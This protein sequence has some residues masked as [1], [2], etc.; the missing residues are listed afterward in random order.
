MPASPSDPTWQTHA[1]KHGR[2][3]LSRTVR[4]VAV[5]TAMAVLVGLLGYLV[6]PP[7]FAART[8]LF[9]IASSDAKRS[10]V[11]S[12]AY[13]QEDARSLESI[14]STRPEDLSV[15]LRSASAISRLG[16]EV[17]ANSLRPCDTLIV[18]LAAHG[19]ADETGA[20]LLA[21]DFDL[22]KPQQGRVEIKQLL[23]EI[24]RSH[25]GTKLVIV[26]AGSIDHDPRLGLHANDF[27]RQLADAVKETGDPTLWVL[28][29]HGERQQ[30]HRV[31]LVRRTVFGSFVS[32]GLKGAADVNRDGSVTLDEL[33]GFTSSNVSKWVSA[34]TN[35][36][37]RQTPRLTWGGVSAEQPNPLLLKLDRRQQEEH[38]TTAVIFGS[39]EA[40]SQSLSQNQS[41][42]EITTVSVKARK[43]P[44]EQLSQAW[45]LTE[46]IATG[47]SL[48]SAPHLL[49]EQRQQLMMLDRSIRRGSQEERDDAVSTL[50]TLLESLAKRAPKDADTVPLETNSDEVVESLNALHGH[51]G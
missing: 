44:E 20:S 26:N 19:I 3:R 40:G 41:D 1:P 47:A 4:R 27:P 17:V 42:I 11:A 51:V 23:S 6:L 34:S 33:V 18:Y 32:A 37:A 7:F 10:D 21:D 9:L 36:T 28:C 12:L 43:S 22:R 25:A 49:R 2:A 29:S 8:K 50:E 5:V 45:R 35:R 39:D 14:P 13:V 30:S 31:D 16:D 46:Q 24:Q 38:W 15:A 48:Q